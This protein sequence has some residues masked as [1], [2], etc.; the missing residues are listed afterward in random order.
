MAV[1]V[2]VA[3]FSTLVRQAVAAL[4]QADGSIIVATAA[5]E[6][7]TRRACARSAPAVIVIEGLHSQDGALAAPMRSLV[8][9]C[10]PSAGCVVLDLHPVCLTARRAASV[11]VGHVVVSGS[12][13]RLALLHAIHDASGSAGAGSSTAVS[14]PAH[15]TV[16][17]MEILALLAD[18]L[19]NKEIGVRLG[20][21]LQTAKNHIAVL[22]HKLG[23]TDRAQLAVYCVEHGLR[24]AHGEFGCA[25]PGTAAPGCTDRRDPEP[26]GDK[27][28]A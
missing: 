20:I 4:L 28:G 14:A 6:E 27:P 23:L 25:V 18:G 24:R 21:G 26:P 19:S 7:E 17:E 10:C 16:R 8:A 2:L 3:G 9:S 12:A 15:L 22:L 13:D 1:P 5:D 11:S